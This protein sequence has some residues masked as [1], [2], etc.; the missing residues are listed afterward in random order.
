MRRGGRHARPDPVFFGFNSN[1]NIIRKYNSKHNSISIKRSAKS[2]AGF[3][4]PMSM[5]DVSSDRPDAAGYEWLRVPAVIRVKPAAVVPGHRPWYVSRTFRKCGADYGPVLD[6]LRRIVR[7]RCSD[8]DDDANRLN[9]R[10][11]GPAAKLVVRVNVPDADAVAAVY[12]NGC[13]AAK[14]REAAR[15]AKRARDRDASE[16]RRRMARDDFIRY[17]RSDRYGPLWD[18]LVADG[19]AYRPA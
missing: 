12:A 5:C 16:A 9:R 19:L 10:L 17:F 14:R 7:R 2:T 8:D 4:F 11:P 3:E 6:A 18:R 1:Y 15:S 13:D